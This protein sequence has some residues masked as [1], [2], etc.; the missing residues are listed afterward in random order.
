MNY[1]V[2]SGQQFE[3]VSDHEYEAVSDHEYEGIYE[4]PVRLTSFS[5]IHKVGNVG[6]F[7]LL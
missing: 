1:F 7:V 3:G 4:E 2:I 5:I 6:F